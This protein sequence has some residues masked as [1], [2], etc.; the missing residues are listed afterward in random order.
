MKGPAS[1]TELSRQLYEA[2][3]IPK[4]FARLVNKL[5]RNFVCDTE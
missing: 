1:Q 3:K 4:I 5:V 2:T